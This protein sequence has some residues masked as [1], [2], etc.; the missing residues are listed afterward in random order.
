MS[1]V[2]LEIDELVSRLIHLSSQLG[3]HVR[4]RGSLGIPPPFWQWKVIAGSLD[5]VGFQGGKKQTGINRDS[6][7]RMAG[8]RKLVAHM[9]ISD[10]K[11][12][13]FLPVVYLDLPVIQVYLHQG[14][15][16]RFQVGGEQIRFLSVIETPI[17]VRAVGGRRDDDQTQKPPLGTALP[18]DFAHFFVAQLAPSAAVKKLPFLP[19]DILVFAHLFGGELAAVEKPPA[20]LACAQT[21]PGIFAGA[22]NQ[23]NPVEL[24]T[25]KGAVAKTPVQR[26]HGGLGAAF[27]VQL[28][29]QGFECFDGLEHS[30]RLFFLFAVFSFFFFG[31]FLAGFGKGG[32]IFEKHGHR[33]RRGLRGFAVKRQEASDLQITQAIDE[34]DMKRWRHRVA[35]TVDSGHLFARFPGVGEVSGQVDKG[36]F[37]RVLDAGAQDWVKERLGFP[38]TTVEKLVVGRPI[39]LLAAAGRDEPADHPLTR[40]EHMG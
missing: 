16:W 2:R 6:E 37:D 35:H 11:I 30:P 23:F 15:C 28:L 25:E 24:G 36:F 29:A 18:I 7:G 19:W 40:S 8:H 27:P 34:V 3:D 31:G 26:D 17:F 5:P 20:P 9:G 4:T 14:G 32:H 1:F 33:A 39:A 21:Q 10:P 22:A 13:F 38:R 12:A